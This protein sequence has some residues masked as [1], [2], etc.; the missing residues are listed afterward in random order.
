MFLH[1]LV[2]SYEEVDGVIVHMGN[3]ISCKIIAVGSVKVR[4]FDGIIR[5]L[6]NIKHVPE[7]KMILIH[8]GG[9]DF[10]GRKFI[11]QGGA[12][13]VSK[14][15]LMIMKANNMR[16]LYKLDRST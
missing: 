1:K 4:I 10:G 12:L 8:L 2:F 9:L 13:K 15:S 11:G 7:L 6:G 16:N 5:T 3:N 14:H